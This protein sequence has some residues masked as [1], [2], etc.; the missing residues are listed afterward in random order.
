MG[1]DGKIKVLI[2]DDSVVVRSALTKLLARDA[3]IQV[4]GSAADPYEAREKIVS[5]KPDVLTLDIEMPR[6]DGMT[7]LAKIMQHRPMPVVMCSSVT[8]E[9]ADLSL[10]AIELGALEVV[11]KPSSTQ[12]EGL[13]E[14]AIELIDKIKAAARANVRRKTQPKQALRDDRGRPLGVSLTTGVGRV[15]GVGYAA[16]QVLPAPPGLARAQHKVV[17]IG[18]STGGTEALRVVLER[19]PRE[20]PGIL[21]VQHM[22]EYFTLAFANRLNALC[23]IDV[24]EAESG[25]P[26]RP[27]L[28]LIAPG[29]SHLILRRQGMSLVADVR[30]GPL[31]CRHRPSVEVLFQSVARVAGPN[32][33]GVM[34][35]GMGAD[36]AQG[37]ALL[38][39]AG[40]WNIAQDEASCVVYGM[41]KEAVKCGGVDKV[42]HLERIAPAILEACCRK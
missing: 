8:Q 13:H 29:N 16:G 32:A 42:E 22:P 30:S 3:G 9:G 15:R 39:Q 5:L 12:M 40:A 17:A 11:S 7:F 18:A 38:K 19:L 33:V 2:V 10:K 31:V 4:V 41:P 24:K 1:T 6:M 37:M 25:D 36:G 14:V 35:T 23:E 20:T 28:A 26:I 21:I 34:L 27:G